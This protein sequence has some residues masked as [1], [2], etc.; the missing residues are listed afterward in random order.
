MLG[1]IHSVFL[2]ASVAVSAL[3]V[4]FM[5]LLT[6]LDAALRKTVDITNTGLVEY[7]TV[8]LVFVVYAAMAYTHSKDGHVA[9]TVLTEAVG[10]KVEAWIRAFA[11][12]ACV[13]L[14]VV[15]T[16]AAAIAFERSVASGEATIGSVEI[17]L[18]IPRLIIVIGCG[19]FILQSVIE[20]AREFRAAFGLSKREG[21]ADQNPAGGAGGAPAVGDV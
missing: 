1:K 2:R 18:W 19:L 11:Q 4:L 6:V 3:V 21:A 17:K 10:P 9:F 13:V 7:A 14:G 5:M 8:A 16:Y 12:V 20:S 15:L